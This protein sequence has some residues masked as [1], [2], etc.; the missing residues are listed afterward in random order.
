M[1]AIDAIKGRLKTLLS[2]FFTASSILQATTE[3]L[4]ALLNRKL[5]HITDAV[6]LRQHPLRMSLTLGSVGQRKTSSIE[7]HR[8]L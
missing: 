7:N 3:D 6:T 8:L 5:D 2:A 1:L 4:I